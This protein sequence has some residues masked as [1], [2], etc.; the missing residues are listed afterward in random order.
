MDL[1]Y[2]L[3]KFYSDKKWT[4]ADEQIGYDALIWLDETS[5]KPSLEE[6][7]R[8]WKLI[9]IEYEN[10]KI[11]AKRQLEYPSIYDYIDGIVKNDKEQIQRYI[12]QC[13]E[14]KA[15][16]PKIADN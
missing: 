7:E 8:Y 11:R 5:P 9:E 10:D 6:L 16:Y 15:K 2:V 3:T 1:T 12:D 4:V 14:V 13:L